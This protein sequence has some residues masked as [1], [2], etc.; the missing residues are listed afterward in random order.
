MKATRIAPVLLAVALAACNAA[1]QPA[2]PGTV[3]PNRTPAAATQAPA[4][5]QPS[6]PQPEPVEVDAGA[7]TSPTRFDGYGPLRFGMEE[8]EV[9]A[10]W[11]GE[12]SNDGA[13]DTCHFLDPD[14]GQAPAV[15][16]LMIESGKFVRYDVGTADKVAPGGGKVG[17]EAAEIRALYPGRVEARPHHYV[18]GG[19]YLRVPA[20]QGD[21]L[22]VFET[23]A[24][25]KVTR[26]R[27]GV[28][29]QVDYIEGCA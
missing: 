23:D 26:W 28:A 8:K 14:D 15:F 19:Q 13:G 6:L 12:L 18:E 16:A 4:D 2:T 1:D 7:L 25:G 10:A 21:G 17:M 3:E 11:D 22:L 27:A 5:V 29:P 24:S 20:E 9:L